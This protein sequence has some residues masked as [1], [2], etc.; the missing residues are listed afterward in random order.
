MK[1]LSGDSERH[2]VRHNGSNPP[3]RMSLQEEEAKVRKA[4]AN[5][6]LNEAL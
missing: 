5:R 3:P 1:L 6:T 2:K 4:S